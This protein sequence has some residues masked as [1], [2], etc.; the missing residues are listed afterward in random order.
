[1]SRVQHWSSSEFEGELRTWVEGVVGPVRLEVQKVRPWSATW[2]AH[3]AD[4]LYFA[5]QN[6]PGSRFEASLVRFLGVVAPG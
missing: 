6:C 3:A 4:G 2:R 1:M 5:K